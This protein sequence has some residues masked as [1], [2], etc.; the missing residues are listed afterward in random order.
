MIAH[1]RH[2]QGAKPKDNAMTTNEITTTTSNAGAMPAAA[3]L[4]GLKSDAGRRSMESEL[5]KIAA[6][7][8]CITTNARGEVIGDWH[9]VN[10]A[11]LNAANVR[12]IMAKV[13]GAP[14]TRNKTL[15]ALKGVARAA[16][17]MELLPGEAHERIRRVKGDDGKREPVGR[18]IEPH[19]LAALMR[20]CAD[21]TP[22]GKR[23]AAIIA[24]AAKT[25]AR[26]DELA[27]M[28]RD[29]MTD[30][31]ALIEI[32]VIGKRDKQR[33]LY[34]DNGAL[35]ALRAWLE[36]CPDCEFVFAPIS[37]LGDVR[38]G[39]MSNVAMHKILQRRAA[40]A[41]LPAVSW[42]DFRRTFAGQLLDAGEDI[43]T[44]A[45]MMGHSSVN[46]TA[47]YDRRPAEARRR[48]A[49]RITV[50]YFGK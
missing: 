16:Y 33:T 13:T 14:A 6:L 2:S 32:R 20:A 50:P 18:D 30:R 11:T 28:R 44:V 46:T 45:A 5:R 1:S 23:D 9:A 22:A 37:Q 17:D 25:G 39:R 43:A 19:E 12:A 26:R 27:G 34:V 31:G 42:H 40:Q 35:Q 41:G 36:L 48:A 21:G 8:G 4:A 47:R 38:R 49:A 15:A 3:Y 7:M 29:A 10:W 24:L